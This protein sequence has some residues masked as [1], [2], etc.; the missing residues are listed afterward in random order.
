MKKGKEDEE[1]KRKADQP[2]QMQGGFSKT[3]E[4]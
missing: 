1:G 4:R 2:E 3:D